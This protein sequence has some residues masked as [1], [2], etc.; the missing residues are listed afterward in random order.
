MISMFFVDE[1]YNGEDYKELGEYIGTHV[2]EDEKVRTHIFLKEKL[3][4]A[5]AIFKDGLSPF[6]ISNDWWFAIDKIAQEYGQAHMSI[7]HWSR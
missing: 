3:L 4:E 7:V 6:S 5:Y 1:K 2:T